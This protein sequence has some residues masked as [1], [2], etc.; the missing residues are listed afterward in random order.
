MN[1]TLT[2]DDIRTG[3]AGDCYRCAVALALQRATGDETAHVYEDEDESGLI[4]LEAHGRSVQAPERVTRFVWDY[5]SLERSSDGR[6]V[7]TADK[8]A[9]LQPF[10]F[11]LPPEEECEGCNT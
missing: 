5:D 4:R 9:M 10:T 7:I 1:V 6:P 11:T 3:V 2:V 8:A